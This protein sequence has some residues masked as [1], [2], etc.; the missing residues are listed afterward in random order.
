MEDFSLFLVLFQLVLTSARNIFLCFR[1]EQI[2]EE[3]SVAQKGEGNDSD[4]E[5]AD[6]T[7]DRRDTGRHSEGC[8]D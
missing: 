7:D 1:K 8:S 5:E 2:I 4:E 3:Y 6:S